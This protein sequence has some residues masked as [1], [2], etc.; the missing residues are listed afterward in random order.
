[1]GDSMHRK[2][3]VLALA[4]ALTVGV[5]AAW[6]YPRTAS[7]APVVTSAP[8][9]AKTYTTKDHIEVRCE[10]YDNWLLM[11]AKTDQHKGA[12]G[13]FVRPRKQTA[14]KDECLKDQWWSEEHWIS[15]SEGKLALAPGVASEHDRSIMDAVGDTL[16]VS[17][18]VYLR[19]M[20]GDLVE[21]TSS[22]TRYHW[23][24]DVKTRTIVWADHIDHRGFTVADRTISYTRLL[25]CYNDGDLCS[26]ALEQLGDRAKCKRTKR[27]PMADLS[28]PVQVVLVAGGP[29]QQTIG[30]G[31]VAC[32]LP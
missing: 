16:W 3:P 5:F 10:V 24:I 2:S 11:Q 15:A 18:D 22:S 21:V 4:T 25:D 28:Y 27:P 1:M 32:R 8:L 17:S 31:P 13:A 30:K 12:L 9:H 7:A 29:P 6:C 14:A 20:H 26:A 23:L 19:R